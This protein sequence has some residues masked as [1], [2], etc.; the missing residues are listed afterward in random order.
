M[1]A[2]V[3]RVAHPV[4]KASIVQ[5]VRTS[6]QGRVLG[7]CGWEAF[8]DALQPLQ[9]LAAY[10]PPSNVC[11]DN[12]FPSLSQASLTYAEPG[13]RPHTPV[14][15]AISCMRACS[16]RPE[17]CCIQSGFVQATLAGLLP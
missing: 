10:K 7:C 17:R 13:A 3:S 15:E 9:L 14:Q 2:S 6:Q 4:R 1:T 16:V 5:S 8:H 11:K 12:R